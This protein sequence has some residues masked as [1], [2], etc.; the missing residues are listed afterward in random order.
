[1]TLEKNKNRQPVR[2]ICLRI[3]APQLAPPQPCGL[4]SSQIKRGHSG[5]RGAIVKGP[6]GSNR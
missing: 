4:I 5:G 1:M 3:T 6:T 2:D